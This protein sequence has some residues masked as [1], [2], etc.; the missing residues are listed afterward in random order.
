MAFG[1]RLR[2]TEEDRKGTGRW[3]VRGIKRRVEGGGKGGE[4]RSE[5]CADVFVTWLT[6]L[7][8][9]WEGAKDAP[10]NQK[11]AGCSIALHAVRQ[12]CDL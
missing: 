5:R 2:S 1:D 7:L 3:G 11:R 12:R 4:K 10:V 6:L 9:L 8:E